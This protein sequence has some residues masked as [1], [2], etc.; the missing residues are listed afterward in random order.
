M[1]DLERGVSQAVVHQGFPALIDELAPNHSD[2]PDVASNLIA[3]RPCVPARGATS[4][5]VSSLD[6]R[7]IGAHVSTDN[8][9]ARSIPG[10]VVIQRPGG[11]KDVG[12]FL[13]I[14][15]DLR[16]PIE[17]Q[18]KRLLVI[19]SVGVQQTINLGLIV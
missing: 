10:K 19:V 8:A 12:V 17:K 5:V 9:K 4:D 13:K 15:T 3:S 2:H 16:V 6:Q 1:R 11:A 14:P 18:S 7:P